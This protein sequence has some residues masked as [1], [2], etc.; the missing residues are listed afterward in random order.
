MDVFGTSRRE[1]VI[2]Y[3]WFAALVLAVIGVR[4]LAWP[5]SAAYTFGIGDTGGVGDNGAHPN[6][7]LHYIVGLRD[8]WLAGLIMFAAWTKSMELLCVWFVL[9]AAVCFSDAVIV[10]HL[11]GPWQAVLF[12]VLSGTFCAGVALATYAEMRAA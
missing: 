7:G 8:I 6:F 12:H 3:G 11:S 1:R 2:G 9:G 5:E 10:I 4:F